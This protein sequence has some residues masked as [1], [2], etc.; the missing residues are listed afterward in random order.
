MTPPGPITDI[1]CGPGH[2]TRFLAARCED[3]V[4]LDLSPEMIAMYSSWPRAGRRP[5]PP[6]GHRVDMDGC[7]LHPTVVTRD[8][9]ANGFRVDARLALEPIS[10]IEFAS[11][12]CYILARRAVRSSHGP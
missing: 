5:P 3:V 10:G 1:G 4:G 7:F 6:H 11:R 9:L 12:R 2:V 8:L